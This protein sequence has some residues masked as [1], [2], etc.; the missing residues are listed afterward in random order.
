MCIHFTQ[1]RKVLQKMSL[2]SFVENSLHLIAIKILL[3]HILYSHKY[4]NIDSILS[5][6]QDLRGIRIHQLFKY[7][8]TSVC[9]EVM[10]WTNLFFVF[11]CLAAK[12]SGDAK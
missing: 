10:H 6:C 2:K 11:V 4:T 3:T 8:Y 1:K 5:R 12:A 9:E 7:D